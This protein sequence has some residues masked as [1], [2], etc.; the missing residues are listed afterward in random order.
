M[1][2]FGT[3]ENAPT[4]IG[5][6]TSD[7]EAV[8]FAGQ[9]LAT[10]NV[11]FLRIGCQRF[12]EFGRPHHHIDLGHIARGELDRNAILILRDNGITDIV[13][14]G[15]LNATVHTADTCRVQNRNRQ[16]PPPLSN[17]PAV[18]TFG[19]SLERA[20]FKLR[21]LADLAP[22][23]TLGGRGVLNDVAPAFD[24]E[25]IDAAVGRA[26]AAAARR[27]CCGAWF[28]DG[29]ASRQNALVFFA[30]DR[31]EELARRPVKRPQMLIKVASHPKH[32]P[33]DPPYLRAM[34][35]E[36]AAK[37]GVSVIAVDSQRGIVVDRDATFAFAKKL[38][39]S[40]VGV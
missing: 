30:E 18:V 10:Q 14:V 5:L 2:L 3:R 35:V 39:V 40:I 34:T 12:E 38:G 17:R 27:R 33:L 32:C 11:A 19:D 36:R 16:V 6:I 21:W 8:R 13:N 4:V 20:G 37:A 1:G 28:D 31:L 24:S 9:A 25:T 15:T 22:N 23:M 29:S 7:V 26:R